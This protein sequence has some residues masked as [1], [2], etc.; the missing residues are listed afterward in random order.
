MKPPSFIPRSAATMDTSTTVSE[1][2]RL[3]AIYA[4]TFALFSLVSAAGIA[5]TVVLRESRRS[6]IVFTPYM[7]ALCS[8]WL[9]GFY[10]L[11]QAV[12]YLGIPPGLTFGTQ[13]GRILP[14]SCE[15]NMRVYGKD[16]LPC[17]LTRFK[18]WLERSFKEGDLRLSEIEESWARLCILCILT[19]LLIATMLWLGRRW[20]REQDED[21]AKCSEKC[22]VAACQ[23]RS[24][25]FPGVSESMIMLSTIR[26]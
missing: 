19:M 21:K 7:P 2:Q 20:K 18:I 17:S 14:C 9:F 3:V 6:R 5:V 23:T 15:G 10:P 11:F 16:A 26:C 1:I 13:I 4:V 8:M 22:V 25:Q 24:V 12:V